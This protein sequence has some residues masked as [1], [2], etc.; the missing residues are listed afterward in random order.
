M[1][2]AIPE[3]TGNYNNLTDCFVRM[4]IKVEGDNPH[5]IKTQG[6]VF[7][8]LK[9]GMI[10]L[11]TPKFPFDR[12]I[13]YMKNITIFSNFDNMEF[14]FEL[15]KNMNIDETS[16]LFFIELRDLELK[17]IKNQSI[18]VDKNRAYT[19]QHLLN[20]KYCDVDDFRNRTFL[21]QPNYLYFCSFLMGMSASAVQNYNFS[22]L[23]KNT[24]RRVSFR[25]TENFSFISMPDI[26]LYNGSPLIIE[27]QNSRAKIG[28]I[29]VSTPLIEELS[30]LKSLKN[31]GILIEYYAIKQ[32]IDSL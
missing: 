6:I 11:L 2:F 16:Y 25:D 7:G 12:D 13:Q 3:Y 30:E 15:D 1:S 32:L 14:E 8:D 19:P 9:R 5:H 24:H 31:T 21:I 18:I 26:D 4:N 17:E 20:L 28:G 29:L 27:Q 23:F 22:I 10:G